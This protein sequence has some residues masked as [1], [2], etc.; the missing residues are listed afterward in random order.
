MQS[1]AQI[2]RELEANL[3]ARAESIEKCGSDLRLR[4]NVMELCRR[5]PI[6]WIN[7]FAWTKDPK[8]PY[9]VVPFI[10]YPE[11]QDRLVLD[12]V[13]A[14]QNGGDLGIEKTREMGVSWIVLYVFTWFWLFTPNSDFFVGSPKKDLVYK[15]I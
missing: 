4:A 8:R 11:F 12:L 14:I 1:S 9:K 10:L 5:D 3:R 7:L 13:D 6:L 2:P 15:K